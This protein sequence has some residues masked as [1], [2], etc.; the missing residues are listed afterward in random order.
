MG[1]AALEVTPLADF[2]FYG[3]LCHAPL[4]RAVLGRDVLLEPAHLPGHAVFWAETRAFPL[5][6]EGGEGAPGGVLRGLT[7][8]DIRRLDYYEGGFGSETRE[9]RIGGAAVP[10]QVYLPQPGRWTPGAPWSLADWEARW[11]AAVVAAAEEAMRLFAEGVDPDRVQARYP[12]MLAR[13]GARVRAATIVPTRVRRAAAPGDIVPERLRQPYQ[14]FFAV[15]E[16]DLSFRRFDGAMSATVN[17]A[18]FISADA[19]VVLP[20]DPVRDRVMLIEQFRMGPYARG[21][22]EPWLLEA[23]AGRIDG[24]ETPEEAAHRE[25]MEEAGL[26]LRALLPATHYYPSPSA[27][28]EFLYTYVGI[29]DLPDGITGIGGVPGEAEDIRSH[30]MPFDTLLELVETGEVTAG[31]LALLA[32][33]LAPR[34]AA[35]RRG[36]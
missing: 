10:A 3:T 29:A 36:A 8:E 33:W 16:F 14:N 18:V 28:S 24:G 22:R 26:T 13:A 19:A 6:V 5:L 31:P 32:Y 27:K 30:L 15:E 34:R 2:F 21:D 17:R 25:A 7:P 35:L 1:S 23:I 9:V 12:M 20:Y 11:G 4:L